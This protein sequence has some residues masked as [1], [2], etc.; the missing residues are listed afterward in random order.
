M[1]KV[2]T[3]TISIMCNIFW[4]AGGTSNVEMKTAIVLIIIRAIIR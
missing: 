4:H 1:V 3:V 2:T